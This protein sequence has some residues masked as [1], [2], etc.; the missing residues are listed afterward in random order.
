MSVGFFMGI[1]MS[2]VILLGSASLSRQMLLRDAGID[3]EL[4]T[5]RA[6]E[7]SCDWG[8]P[9]PH[10][11]EQIAVHKMEHVVLGPGSDGQECFV[12]TADTLTQDSRGKI[13]GKPVDRADELRK[14][15]VLREGARVG[16]AFCL[17][18]KIF[19]AGIWQTTQRVVKFVM[20]ECFFDIP[21]QWVAPYLALGQGAGASGGM[22]IE[23]FGS[24]FLKSVHGSYTTI[25]G[26]PMFELREALEAIGFYE[27]ING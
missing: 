21:D 7:A 18:K 13:H 11:V 2:K 4:V 16:T 9:L 14:I 5:S 10:L 15:H 23:G 3:F 8:L 20:A 22:R 17:D 25:I 24:L 1:D 6:D 27:F 12:L 26:L 19:S